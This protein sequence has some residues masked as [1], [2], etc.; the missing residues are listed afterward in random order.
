MKRVLVLALFLGACA[1]FQVCKRVKTLEAKSKEIE[2]QGRAQ[3]EFQLRK[4]QEQQE[5][6]NNIGR[7]LYL[8][9]NKVMDIE[10]KDEFYDQALSTS[11][12]KRR[13]NLPS[14]G[15]P[16]GN[17]KAVIPPTKK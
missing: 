4:G 10:K 17:N 1:P 5:I 12:A 11:T 9:N 15:R 8:I 3:A 2:A 14:G 7:L 13:S 16:N 6:N